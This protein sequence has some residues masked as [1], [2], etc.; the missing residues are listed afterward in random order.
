MGIRSP[1][2]FR[3]TLLILLGVFV[4]ILTALIVESILQRQDERSK[5]APYVLVNPTSIPTPMT[6][7]QT[8]SPFQIKASIPYWD[9]QRGFSSFKKNIELIGFL[10]LFWYYLTHEGT[11]EPYQ[12]A[13]EDRTI[14]DYAHTH[15]VK[16]I[17]VI[18]NL[19][20]EGEWD[21]HRVELAIGDSSQRKKHIGSIVEK[22]N[23]LGFDGV[24]ID[25][26]NVDGSQ[27]E[28]FSLFIHELGGELHKKGKI[29][30]VAVHPKTNQDS[31]NENGVF[32]DWKSLARDADQ[33]NI[34][35][36]DE[37]WDES[38]PGPI[39]STDWVRRII[40]YARTLGLPD[41]KLFLGVPLYGYDWA[42]KDGLVADG[43]T[44]GE[45]QSLLRKA[46]GE[47]KWD[48]YA[49][50][51]HFSYTKDDY[52]HEVWFENAKSTQEKIRLA[53]EAGFGG[54]AFWRLGGED[55]AVWGVVQDAVK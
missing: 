30:M 19:P 16:V 21:S 2:L 24:D 23:M 47:E 41:E 12:Y 13:K 34:M 54:V 46:G 33:I 27:R 51:P 6:V 17:A 45:A 48:V 44:Y 29:L 37:H 31:E 36:Y 52:I 22:M 20:N 42:K 25:Y 8:S 3:Y 49:Q 43:L 39:A 32:Q 11:I 10:Q 18:T 50:S 38:S 9:Q 14:I 15:G 35:A 1:I 4:C 26:E 40:G 7:S 28:N 5:H 55:S 53:Q